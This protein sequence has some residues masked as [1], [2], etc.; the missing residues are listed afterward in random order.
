ALFEVHKEGAAGDPQLFEDVERLCEL[1]GEWTKYADAVDKLGADA[2][3]GAAQTELLKRL[4]RIAETRLSDLPRAIEA[5]RKAAEQ[6]DEPGELLAALDR[7]YVA[8]KD[9]E[10]LAG[11]LDRRIELEN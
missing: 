9:W 8:T 3:D 5:Y 6:S 4:G 2:Y 1:T 7:L 10:K 11:V